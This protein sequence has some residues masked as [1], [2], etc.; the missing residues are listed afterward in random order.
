V[1]EEVLALPDAGHLVG[2]YR[3][4]EHRLFEITGAWSGEAGAPALRVHLFEASHQ[5]AWHADMWADRLPVLDGTDPEAL[6]VPVGPVAGPLLDELDELAARAASGP[7]ADVTWLTGLCRVVLPR[8][9]ATYGRHLA[10]ASA[11]TDAPTVRVLRLVLR[12]E[13]ESWQAGESLLQSFIVA[14][15]NAAAAAAAQTRLESVVVGARVGAGVGA[16]VGGAAGAGVGIM[17]W[18]GAAA[19]ANGSGPVVAT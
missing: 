13:V 16:D 1:G 10:A 5:H 7:D 3:W 11:V 17:P 14:P 4:L 19:Q 15:E 2:G 18:P 8:L 9:I 6:T 12:D